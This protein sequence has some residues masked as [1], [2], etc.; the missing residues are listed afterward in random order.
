MTS[1]LKRPRSKKSVDDSGSSSNIDSDWE[2]S[3]GELES[4]YNIAKQELTAQCE[5][6]PQAA[7]IL[8]IDLKVH[9]PTF[10]DCL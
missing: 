10:C 5:L 6:Q 7:P 4:K 1:K 2:N 9:P 8:S 3:L